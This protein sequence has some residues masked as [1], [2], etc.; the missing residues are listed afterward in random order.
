[1]PVFN[2]ASLKSTISLVN[3]LTHIANQYGM[4][5]NLGNPTFM[6]LSVLLK[7]VKEIQLVRTTESQTECVDLTYD[8]E[9]DCVLYKVRVISDMDS[10][11]PNYFELIP[12]V[13]SYAT[14]NSITRAVY[15]WLKATYEYKEC[16]AY[17]NSAE[18]DILELLDIPK[19][20]T[21]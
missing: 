5:E 2:S 4:V 21:R 10:K 7:R 11:S 12:S 19:R 13:E 8:K 16:C 1:M 18:Y 20:V 15:L 14:L 6:E 17:V 9:M 3:R